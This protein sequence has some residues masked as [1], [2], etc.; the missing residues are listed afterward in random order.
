MTIPLMILAFLA[1]AG[2][3]LN[4][5]ELMGGSRV[6]KEF[7]APVFADAVKLNQIPHMPVPERREWFNIALVLFLVLLMAF[8]AFRKFG[9]LKPDD[10]NRISGIGARSIFGKLAENK[11][12]VDELYDAV[13]VKP[14]LKV[15]G[16]LHEFIEV[17]FIDRIVN[18][19]GTLVVRFSNIIRYLQAGHVGAYMFFMIIGILLILFFNIIL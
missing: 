5:P 3:F 2:G 6:L 10:G 13:F 12:Y 14:V 18:G 4:I 16:A 17:K 11:F 7:L 9:D 1:F 8:R 19:T 15:S